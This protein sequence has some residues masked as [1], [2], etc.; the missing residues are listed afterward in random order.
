MNRAA[1]YVISLIAT[2]LIFLPCFAKEQNWEEVLKNG[3]HLLAIGET[4]K[5]ISFFEQKTKKYPTSGACHTYLGRALKRL[6]KLDLAKTEFKT[7]TEVEPG[8]ADGYYELGVL[9]ESDKQWADAASAFSR[10]IELKPDNSQRRTIEDRIK[11]CKGQ[12]E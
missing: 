10:Y 8:Y 2:S 11:Y 4:E 6:G 9:Q 5:A 1:R 7:A 3:S 12:Q